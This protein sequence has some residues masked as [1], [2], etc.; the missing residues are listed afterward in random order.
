MR[1]EGEKVTKGVRPLGLTIGGRY[2]GLMATQLCQGVATTTL[3]TRIGPARC[4]ARTD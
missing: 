2:R 4:I 1:L 3:K